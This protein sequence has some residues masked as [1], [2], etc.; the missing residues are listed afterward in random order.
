MN[1]DWIEVNWICLILGF[2][3]AILSLATDNPKIFILD[4]IKVILLV[5]GAG[6]AS[7]YGWQGSIFIVSLV[8]AAIFLIDNLFIFD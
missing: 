5:A 4:V 1:I 2:I 3:V 8:I 6:F 7:F